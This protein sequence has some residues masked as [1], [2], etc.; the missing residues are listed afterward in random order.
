MGLQISCVLCVDRNFKLEIQ[1]IF[2]TKSIFII[3][4]KKPFDT[5]HTTH[6]IYFFLYINK[7]EC[8]I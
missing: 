3:M 8:L 5:R 2:L 7:L 4:I 1:K 6:T